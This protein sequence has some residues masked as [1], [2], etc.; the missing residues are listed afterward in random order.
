MGD[1]KIH[2]SFII[3]IILSGCS[4]RILKT[5]KLHQDFFNGKD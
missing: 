3:D 4:T 1:A 2:K 5:Q